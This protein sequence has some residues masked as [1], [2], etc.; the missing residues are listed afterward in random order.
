MKLNVG[1]PV[2]GDE[3][4]GRT[5][6]VKLMLDTLKAGQSVALIA[7]R[8]FGKTSLML[9]VLKQLQNEGYYTGNIDIFTIP[10]VGQLSFEI[11]KQVLKNRKLDEAFHKFRNNLAEILQNIKFRNEIQDAEFILSFGKPERDEWEQL[12]NSLNFI[13]SFSKKHNKENCFAFDEFGDINKLDGQDIVK[14][15]RAV[16]QKHESSVYIFTGSY[17]SVMDQLFVTDKSPF[18]RMV[19]IIEPGFLSDDVIKDFII[20]KFN[21][22]EIPLVEDHIKEVVK[23]THGHPYY[24][25]LF[26]QEYFFQYRDLGTNPDI[27][28]VVEEMLITEKNYIEKLWDEISSKK[29][30]R[31]IILKIITSGGRPYTNIDNR[32]VNV[33]RA[34]NELRGKGLIISDGYTYQLT[35]PLLE[36]YLRRNVLKQGPE[37]WILP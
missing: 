20:D 7:P 21:L 35:D 15:F 13:E 1:R 33:S 28:N 27:E 22:L 10:D 5:K 9:E 3:L 34:I 19:R 18:Y 4:V 32:A 11:T 16:V 17:E 12:K 29:E 25:R 14:L 37:K 6:E 8:R 31:L 2:T 23:I 36:F 24:T 30:L 26:I